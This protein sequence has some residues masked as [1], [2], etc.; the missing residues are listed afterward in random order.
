MSVASVAFRNPEVLS[1]QQKSRV[2]LTS[3]YM[4]DCRGALRRAVIINQG[5]IKHDGPLAE[6]VERFS[7]N[8]VIT[9]QFAGSEVPPDLSV[10]GNVFDLQPP[11]AKLASARKDPRV[12]ASVLARYPIEDVGVQNARWKKSSPSSSPS[13]PRT[14]SAVAA[15]SYRRITSPLIRIPRRTPP[16]AANVPPA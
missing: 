5:E 1:G 2:I 11:R 3:H 6:I 15:A 8:K 13:P 10:Y 12:L 4:K 7:R 9:L 14:R 16:A